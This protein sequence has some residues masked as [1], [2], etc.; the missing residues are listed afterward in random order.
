ML[1]GS[2]SKHRSLFSMPFLPSNGRQALPSDVS[3][4]SKSCTRAMAACVR[5]RLRAFAVRLFGRVRAP[6]VAC[7][8]CALQ[9]AEGRWRQALVAFQG[10]QRQGLRLGEP[11]MK[12]ALRALCAE[13]LWAR[14]LVL[15]ETKEV[16]DLVREP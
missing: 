2:K 5:S 16:A 7:V 8:T 14:G 13:R 11:T 9:A 3:V 12:A 10:A 1:R 4:S 15:L 6:D